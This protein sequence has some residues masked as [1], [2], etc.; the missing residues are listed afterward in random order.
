MTAE[1]APRNYAVRVRGFD[2]DTVH[3]RARTRARARFLCA[4]SYHDAGWGS[5]LDG[6]RHIAGARLVELPPSYRLVHR[7]RDEGLL[8]CDE[9]KP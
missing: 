1:T 5:V 3:V 8:Y 6:L 2:F 9:A 4:W 7:G